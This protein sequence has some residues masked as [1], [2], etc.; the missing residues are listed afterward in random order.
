[1]QR[2]SGWIGIALLACAGLGASGVAAATVGDRRAGEDL[3]KQWCSG[4][5]ATEAATGAADTGPAWREIAAD[6]ANDEAHLTAFLSAPH[7]AMEGLS[8]SRQ[9]IAD[10]V[11]YIV[12]LGFE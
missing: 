10:L 3:A 2:R 1:M 7:G 5:H 11:T 4:C 8:L 12:S 9:Q 6:P